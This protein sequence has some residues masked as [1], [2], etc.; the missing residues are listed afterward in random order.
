M[1]DW[2][3]DT[4]LQRSYRARVEEIQAR[5]PLYF[6]TYHRWRYALM[7]IGTNEQERW[8][9]CL[10]SLEAD[11]LHLYPRTRQMDLHVFF[12]RD[13]LRWFGRPA[14]YERYKRNDIWLHFETGERWMRLALRSD[15][16]PMTDLV[17]TLKTLATE[18]VNTA[19]RRHRP[20]I[21][22]GPLPALPAEQ[23][24][25]GAWQ[26]SGPPLELYLMPLHL[27]LLRGE[28]VLRKLALEAIQQIEVMP[29]M[30]LPR[31]SSQGAL[32]FRYQTDEEAETHAYL[33]DDY[34]HVGA[35]LVEAAKR[36][37]E[38]PPIFYG[39]KKGKGN[40]E[41]EDE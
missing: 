16:S 40:Q 34:L 38:E 23:D 28:E 20:Y 8:A 9:A 10:V 19:Y 30:D 2:I 11:G 7:T 29:R 26:A 41:D 4:F 12:A 15:Y 24:L 36:S 3:A 35:S 31:G 37:L 25:L 27:V 17:R 18:A 1:L 13:T 33:V 21:H 39:K 32:R 14:K 5:Q 22:L 6:S